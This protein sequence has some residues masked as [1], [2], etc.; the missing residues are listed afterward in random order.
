MQ[1]L[2]I[3][4]KIGQ[5]FFIGIPGTEA[6]A[7]THKILGEIAPGGICLFTRNIRQAAQTRR[8]LDDISEKLPVP[9]IL[10]LDQEGGLVDRLRRVVTPMPSAHEITTKGGVQEVRELAQITAEAIRILGFNMNFAP[11]V[12]VVDEKREKFSNNGLHSRAFGKSLNDVIELATAYL[13]ELQKNECPGSIKHFPGIG[14]AETDAHDELPSVNISQET[15]RNLD[16]QPYRD[17]IE[18]GLAHSVMVGHAAYPNSGLQESDANGKLLPA[19]LNSKIIKELLRTELGF[20]GLV[21]TDDLEMGAILKNYG[22]GEACKMAI[23]A[24]NDMLLI[25]ASQTAIIEGYEAVLK[26]VKD[27]RISEQR[28]NESLERILAFKKLLQPPLPFDVSRLEELS[29]QIEALKAKL[30]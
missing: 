28:I 7:E 17:F 8:L 25:C 21:I 27:N 22:I 26:A 18:K 20:R 15:L 1:S 16:L 23:N 19:S 5:M 24:G 29:K 3:E 30:N 11:V 9:P 2:T 4:Q 13:E 12:D 10:S 6:D 14:A